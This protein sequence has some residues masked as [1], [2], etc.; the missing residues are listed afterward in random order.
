MIGRAVRGRAR[1]V[2]ARA[3]G[4]LGIAAV[5]DRFM[6]DVVVTREELG[7]L[8]AGLLVSDEPPRGRRR[9][10]E[11]LEASGSE[12]G[13]RYVSELERNFRPYAPI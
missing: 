3:G 6:R 10:A 8:A 11:W 7:A 9:F 4:G 2:R 1:V 13:R 12:L 5:A